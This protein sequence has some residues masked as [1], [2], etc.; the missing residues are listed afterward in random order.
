MINIILLAIACDCTTWELYMSFLLHNAFKKV[1]NENSMH[2]LNFFVAN[3]VISQL[4]CIRVK[5]AKYV[6]GG[7]IICAR[8]K[9][10]EMD[11]KQKK[12]KWVVGQQNPYVKLN[13]NDNF[14]WK[15][16]G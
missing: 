9:R 2:E 3:E 10:W 5:T 6:V 15:L 8:A 1:K 12:K 13:I 4:K 11:K 14:T 16:N 7:N